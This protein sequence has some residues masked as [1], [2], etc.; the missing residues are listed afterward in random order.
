MKHQKTLRELQQVTQKYLSEGIN[1]AQATTLVED[2]L[3]QDWIKR[4]LVF[5]N[6]AFLIGNNKTLTY[7][8]VSPSIENIIGYQ[9][10]EIQDLR[11]LSEKILMKLS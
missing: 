9:A 11:S 4:L 6:Q 10:S 3:E 5:S 2:L 8:Y 7:H 1:L